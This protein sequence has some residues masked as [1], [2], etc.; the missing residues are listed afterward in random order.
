MTIKDAIV[1]G[2]EPMISIYSHVTVP[3][4]SFFDDCANRND[5]L[6]HNC[7]DTWTLFKFEIFYAQFFVKR[8][9][10]NYYI[11]DSISFV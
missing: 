9:K 3:D 6:A 7:T 2:T 8:G 10:Q 4:S 11:F 1:P 5:S